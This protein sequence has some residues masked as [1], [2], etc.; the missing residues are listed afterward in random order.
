MADDTLYGVVTQPDFS[1]L[2]NEN[3]YMDKRVVVWFGEKGFEDFF[4]GAIKKKVQYDG[5]FYV[6]FDSDGARVK[7]KL[8]EAGYLVH[9][10][11]VKPKQESQ[12]DE[13]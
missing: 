9:W 5:H 10:A 11:F 3:L 12:E 8:N 4:I 7:C 1:Y 2:G 13:V 6:K